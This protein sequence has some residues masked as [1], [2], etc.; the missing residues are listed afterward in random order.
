MQVQFEN[1]IVAEKKTTKFEG[2]SDNWA[3]SENN[4]KVSDIK[5]TVLFF[6]GLENNANK[7]KTL[8]CI[9]QKW[10]LLP[11]WKWAKENLKEAFR[12]KLSDTVEILESEFFIVNFCAVLLV[13]D[14]F[15]HTAEPP[16]SCPNSIPQWFLPNFCGNIALKTSQT[17]VEN[18]FE[19]RRLFD[20]LWCKKLNL[21]LK[22]LFW[23]NSV[24]G[25]QP[26]CYRR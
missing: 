15:T 17:S 2:S 13:H 19:W 23:Y 10:I 14:R 24:N 4:F 20:S 9:K 7:Q 26:E 18:N 1:L 21:L 16:R 25:V 5:R 22:L 8:D 3:S 6:P 11:F 12:W